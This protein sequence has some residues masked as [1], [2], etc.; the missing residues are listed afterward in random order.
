MKKVHFVGAGGAGM[1]PLA[2]LFCQSG[3]SVSGSD[4]EENSKVGMLRELG[5]N[6][7]VGHSADNL[8]D[9]AGLLVYSSAVGVD[10]PE[11]TK[12]QKLGIPQLCRGAALA[13]FTGNYRRVVAV[14][15][16]HGKSSITALIS[17]IL[18][19]CGFAPGYMIGAD[20]P[21]R[22]SFSS[23][24]GDIFVT[25]ADESDGT[26]TLLKPFIGVIPNYDPDHAWSVGGEEALEDN[27]T[28]FAGNCSKVICY[29]GSKVREFC[30]GHQN[31]EYLELPS[32]DFSFAGFY[33]YEAVNAFIAV[34]CCEVLGCEREKAAAAAETFS[35]IAR[36]M[37]VRFKSENITV[38]EDYAHHPTEIRNSIA[39]LRR[40]YS[41]C[42]LRIVFQ[43]H[44]YARLEKFFDG[45]AL[46]LAKADSLL[47]TPVFAAWSET[48]KV[49]ASD[50]ARAANGI[51]VGSDWQKTAELAK[52]MPDDGRHLLIAVLGA[53]DINRIFPYLECCMAR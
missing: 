1:A 15:G 3:I 6:I 12:A 23:G 10:N 18:E 9:D 50:L 30:R 11:R 40:K 19:E 41:E 13:Q 4:N 20:V 22:K 43:P 48:G 49:D 25:E 5:A 24:V 34:R 29:S 21:G 38:I 14:S 31:V 33:G 51:C 26:H 35:G 47:V 17:H 2:A 36:R 45:F 53:G 39:L 46:E 8:P 37:T 52:E 42:H 7:S 27:F 16:A 44:R 28:R 32:E